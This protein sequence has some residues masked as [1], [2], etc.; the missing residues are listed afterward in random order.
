[1]PVRPILKYPDPGL[2]IRCETVVRF[3]AELAAL[4]RDLVET[5]RAAP[6]VGITAAHVGVF[7]R[8]FVLELSPAEG[9]LHYVNPDILWSGEETIRFTGRWQENGTLTIRWRFTAG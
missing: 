8:V 5:M 4:A 7:Q 2:S 9:P 6:G 1:M 3:D